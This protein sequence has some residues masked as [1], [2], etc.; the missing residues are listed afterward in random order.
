MACCFIPDNATIRAYV[1]WCRSS[2]L[3]TKLHKT[4]P[5][6]P[7]QAAAVVQPRLVQTACWIHQLVKRTDNPGTQLGALWRKTKI[8]EGRALAVYMPALLRQHV[9]HWH[10]LPATNY[11]QLAA[12]QHGKNMHTYQASTATQARQPNTTSTM[13]ASKQMRQTLQKWVDHQLPPAQPR[14]GTPP[15]A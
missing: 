10:V 4:M 1:G 9:P 13:V 2:H 8:S 14:H 7:R 3:A 5:L 15:A 11:V 6:A 12:Q